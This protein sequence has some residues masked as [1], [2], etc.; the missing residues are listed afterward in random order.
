MYDL[1]LYT[2]SFKEVWHFSKNPTPTEV[3]ALNGTEPWLTTDEYLVPVLENDPFI[4]EFHTQIM[5]R[6]VHDIVMQL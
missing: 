6:I 1:R 5:T 2:V 3:M 4:R